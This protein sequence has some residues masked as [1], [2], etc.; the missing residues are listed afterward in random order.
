M[1]RRQLLKNLGYGSGALVLTP[2][3]MSLLQSCNNEPEFIPVFLS[4]GEG[5]ALR[6]I[7]TLIIPNSDA[8][9][10]AREVGV[11]T[12]I[13]AFYN[14]V[15]EPEDQEMVKVGFTLLGDQF[16]STFTKELEEGKP[17]EFDQLLAKYLKTDKETQ[18]GYNQKMGEFY[19]GFQ[20]DKTLT[21]D[22]D[23]GMF[24][25]LANLRGMTMWAWKESE[26]IGKNVLWYDPVPGKQIGCIPLS[27][28]GNGKAMAL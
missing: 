10:G 27:E 15:L 14:D 17:E 21:P 20:D 5:H 11:H 19:Q 18:K 6:E 16:R 4:K 2:T 7:V 28:A 8:I 22:P 13:D 25:L 9:P 23:A 12:F 1:N 24:S 3:I 26:E